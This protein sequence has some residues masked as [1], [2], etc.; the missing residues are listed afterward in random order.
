MAR[1][2]KAAEALAGRLGAELPSGVARLKAADLARL[3]A[4]VATAA[5]RQAEAVERGA[6]SA[7][8]HVPRILRGPL[9]R[10]LR[11]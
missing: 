1:P 4:L 6:E 7:L 3:D 10:A 9:A 5:E 2:S 8:R 11:G